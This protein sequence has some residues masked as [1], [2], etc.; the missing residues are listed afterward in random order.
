MFPHQP[1]R[2][3]TPKLFITQKNNALKKSGR[4]GSDQQHLFRVYTK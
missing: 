1:C 2:R 4:A 3:K